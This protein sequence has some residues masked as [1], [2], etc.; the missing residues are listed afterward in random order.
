[1]KG[2]LLNRSHLCDKGD[3]K[4]KIAV[5]VVYVFY[6]QKVKAFKQDLAVKGNYVAGLIKTA[7]SPGGWLDLI[8]NFEHTC[9]LHGNYKRTYKNI[10]Y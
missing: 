1:M 7:V 9:T 2:C 8:A 5:I 3:S 10:N 6:L 4:T